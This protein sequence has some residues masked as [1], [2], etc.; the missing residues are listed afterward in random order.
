[1]YNFK[2]TFKNCLGFFLEIYLIIGLFIACGN[3]YISIVFNYER[4]FNCL[5]F[6]S[7]KWLIH[8]HFIKNH[9]SISTE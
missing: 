4:K 8:Q 9:K 3:K 5:W 1:M 2:N 7:Q 6:K